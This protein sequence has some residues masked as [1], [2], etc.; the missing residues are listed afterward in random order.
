MADHRH[1]AAVGGVVVT[2]GNGFVGRAIVDAFTAAGH[3][4]TVL[5]RGNIPQGLP[6]GVVAVAVR[7]LLDVDA[8]ARACEGAFAIVHAAGRA[9][10]VGEDRAVAMQ[11]F[12]ESNVET[13]RCIAHAAVMAGV[14]VVLY[15]SSIAVSERAPDG[16]VT[17]TVSSSLRNPYAI[18]KLEGELAGAAE[19]GRG[20]GRFVSV[21]PPMIYGPGM[22][23]APLHL[24]RW[25]DRHFPLP[26]GGV[27][28]HRSVAG[29]SNVAAA[30]VFL[31]G[32][33]AATGP[34]VIADADAP[35]VEDFVRA[36]ALALRRAP[37]LV[38]APMTV[39]RAAGQLADAVRPFVRL[40]ITTE[41]VERI[42]GPLVADTGAI[43]RLGFFPSTS[44]AAG[45]AAAARWYRHRPDR[46]PE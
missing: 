14:P 33:Q 40:P 12:R 20:G 24:F 17:E 19:M 2:G 28:A 29:I 36:S 11:H 6:P 22:R 46:H 27:R 23:G 13:T 30:V 26:F 3:R 31:A 45:L 18:S 4:V 37:L 41:R 44:L 10:I 16:R 8:M 15:V 7:D 5:C 1:D 43:H 21:R 34:Y 35:S 25:I 38:P 9:H 32:H 39:M 42:F